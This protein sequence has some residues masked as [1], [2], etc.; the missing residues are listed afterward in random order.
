SC[1]PRTCTP[2][3]ADCADITTRRTCNADGLGYTT[4]PCPA[5]HGC[6]GGTCTPWTCTP[7]RSTCADS[8]TRRTC[9]ADGFG[10]TTTA[11]SGTDTCMA[12]TCSSVPLDALVAYYPLDGDASDASGLGGPSG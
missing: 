9:N 11:C 4:T 2:G 5:M 10:Y 6:T 12:G 1:V 7:G 8:H 3:A